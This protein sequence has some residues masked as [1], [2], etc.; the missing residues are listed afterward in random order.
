MNLSNLK[1]A[2]VTGIFIIEKTSMDKCGLFEKIPGFD[3]ILFTND[4]EKIGSTP[5]WDVREIKVNYSRGVYAAKRVKWL[6]HEYLPEYDIIIWIDAFMTPNI[7]MLKDLQNIITLINNSEYSISI[8]HAYFKNI[9]EDIDFCVMHK[10]ISKQ[11]ANEITEYLIKCNSPPE[12]PCK[13]FWSC[14]LIKNNR[15]PN[16]IKFS[17]ELFDLIEKIG[18]R[19]Q[20]WLPYLIN[21]HNLKYHITPNTELFKVTGKITNDR[22]YV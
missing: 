14:S 8:H 7:K 6:T 4:K 13:T 1:I 22:K 20:H 3:Y 5:G 15:D 16:L 12:T 10:R 2:V 9:K 17:E 19:D 21:K 18:Y 11:M